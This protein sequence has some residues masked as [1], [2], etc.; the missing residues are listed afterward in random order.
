MSETC[1]SETVAPWT[2]RLAVALAAAVAATAVGVIPAHAIGG[3]VDAPVIL[4]AWSSKELI[5]VVDGPAQV[6]V[7]IEVQDLGSG[8]APNNPALEPQTSGFALP[9][10]PMT[11]VSGDRFRGI[12]ETTY[13]FPELIP[14]GGWF[15]VARI[16]DAAGNMYPGE[17]FLN[18]NP[19]VVSRPD[20]DAPTVTASLSTRLVDI[21]DGP[22]KVI[23][24]AD[25]YDG[26]LGFP[27]DTT[28][29]VTR[30]MGDGSSTGSVP[31]SSTDPHVA[32]F[33]EAFVYPQ[34]SA[35][36]DARGTYFYSTNSLA[37][38]NGNS[39]SGASLGSVVVATRPMRGKLPTLVANVGTVSAAWAANSDQLGILEYETEFT[40]EGTIRTVRTTATESTL[41]DLPAG[42]YTA[43]VRA[44]NQLGWGEWT[45][46]SA[47]VAYTLASMMSSTPAVSG[48][49]KV[50]QTLTA[51]PGT[52]T[53]GTTLAYQWLAGGVA[54]SG[55]TGSTLVLGPGQAGK[56]I[57]VQ[58][59]GSKPGYAT[60]S[61]TSAVT[62]PVANGVLGG[63]TPTITGTARVGATLTASPGIWSPAPVTLSYQWYSSGVAIPGATAV[64]YNLIA[65]DLGKTI[66]VATT[67]RKSGYNAAVRTSLATAPIATNLLTAPKPAIPA[68]TTVKVGQILSVKTGDWAPTGVVLSYQWKR[69][70]TPIPGAVSASYKVVTADSGSALS[71]T[72]TGRKS[73]YVTKSVTSNATGLATR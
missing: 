31:N 40:S 59:T 23:F 73:G 60:A 72:V 33:R 57:A 28:I 27:A 4:S 69:N 7:R 51:N 30:R 15:F 70:G 48:A 71:I 21:T 43:R 8:L 47:P 17:N 24:S 2:R 34:Y 53:P 65:A 50:G 62:A 64:T 32:T 14:S 45:T 49:V 20:N 61:K 55:A 11:L 56:A 67:A 46:S 26:G 35:S 5:D 12:Y 19:T 42:T 29:A 1:C 54:V 25:G 44:R 41:N 39:A 52:W 36:Q 63:A 22:G 13:T 6:T 16:V 18:L 10:Q 66:T 68:S 58:V 37:D 9:A 3:D 38:V